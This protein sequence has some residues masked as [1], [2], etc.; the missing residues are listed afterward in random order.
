MSFFVLGLP[1]S[2]T[3][4]LANFLT[5][6]KTFCFHEG[7]NGC[8]SMEAYKE[9][10]DGRGDS[11]TGLMLLDLDTHFP[12]AKKIIIETGPER[13]AQFI[14]D[15]Y[16]D[17]GE[18]L[19]GLLKAKLDAVEGLRIP[20]DDLDNRLREVWEYV[21]DE[22]FNT[23]RAEMLKRLRVEMLDPHDLDYGAAREL[24]NA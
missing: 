11:G 18:R 14:T 8:R 20:L 17:D 3:A 16:G 6:G 4:W 1:R 19:A 12:G 23:E 21:S 5:Y 10:L 22:P 7:V 24:M 2:R 15:T 9:K 13:A